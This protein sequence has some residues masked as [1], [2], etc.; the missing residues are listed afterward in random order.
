MCMYGVYGSVCVGS[1]V[2]AGAIEGHRV[3]YSITPCYSALSQ[4]LSKGSFRFTLDWL[5]SELLGATVSALQCW[6]YKNVCHTWL[7]MWV[8]EIWA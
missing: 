2:C 8:L 1:H 7:L 3:S 5:A 6:G 4:G